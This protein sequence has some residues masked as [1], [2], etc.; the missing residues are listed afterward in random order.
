MDYSL[1]NGREGGALPLIVR[2]EEIR[3]GGVLAADLVEELL[4]GEVGRVRLLAVQAHLFPPGADSSEARLADTTVAFAELDGAVFGP[5][6]DID[7]AALIPAT[8]FDSLAQLVEAAVVLTD[9]ADA[10]HGGE[11]TDL[12][13]RLFC[14]VAV[15]AATDDDVFAVS[16]GVILNEVGVER[17]E[18]IKVFLA[19]FLPRSKDLL[20]DVDMQARGGVSLG[21]GQL[22]E[23]GHRFGPE[24][25]AGGIARA[26]GD[27]L[28]LDTEAGN[29]VDGLVKRAVSLALEPV[30]PGIADAVLSTS[31]GGVDLQLDADAVG[32]VV[33]QRSIERVYTL[34]VVIVGEATVDLAL[35]IGR[36]DENAADS[37]GSMRLNDEQV[38]E[39]HR[40]DAAVVREHLVPEDDAVAAED[41]VRAQALT[42]KER[43]I[44]VMG[45]SR[46]NMSTADAF[47]RFRGDDQV[48]ETDAVA[49]GRR[50][51]G[52]AALPDKG[53]AGEITPALNDVLHQHSVRDEDAVRFAVELDFDV[54]CHSNDVLFNP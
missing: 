33:V 12:R 26:Q 42:D 49:N 23:L 17:Q 11:V 16:V 8:G 50:C 34:I 38:V 51:D 46:K 20:G 5:P 53:P 7:V 1:N 28:D 30:R 9:I 31:A 14:M 45:T 19:F 24:I 25:D 43:L 6:A 36:L 32:L 29:A 27:G 18:L 52:K 40:E 4:E 39:D 3:N 10:E 21:D 13:T 2:L 47:A 41:A 54:A 48:I 15:L 44:A 37:R 35:G 22:A